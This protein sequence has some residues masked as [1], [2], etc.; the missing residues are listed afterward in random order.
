[1]T[2]FKLLF[3]EKSQLPSFPNVDIQDIHYGGT[4]AAERY[5]LLQK[6]RSTA[7]Q[8]ATE[9]GLKSKNNFN[10]NT[11]PHKFNIG[12]K[13]FISNDFYVGKNPKLVPT[14]TGPGEIIDIN[15]TKKVKINNI[16]NDIICKFCKLV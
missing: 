11:E 5:N 4:S 12:N 6:L 13:V 10:K 8:F 9:Q 3:G 1:M 15:D 7:L 2:P 16:G 14:F